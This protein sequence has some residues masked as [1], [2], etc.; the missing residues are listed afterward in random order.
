MKYINIVALYLFSLLALSASSV[1]A[2]TYYVSQSG[3]GTA[4]TYSSPCAWSTGVGK[5]IPGDTIYIKG[6]MLKGL[7]LSKSGTSSARITITGDKVSA[8]ASYSDA[9]LVKGA[10]VTISDLEITGGGNFGLRVTGPHAVVSNVLVHD[11]VLNNRNTNGDCKEPTGGWGRGLTFAYTAD[12]AEVSNSQVY[13]N[14]GEGIAFTQNEHSYLHD[15]LAYDNFS[16]NLYIGNA[17]YVTVEGFT[18]YY[19]GN[20]YFYRG[21]Q[22]GRC[23]GLAIETT[24]YSLVGNLMHDTLIQNNN[25][26]NCKG[27]NFYQEVSGQYPSRV[28]VQYNYIYSMVGCSGGNSCVSI[29]GTN[30]VIRNNYNY[31][32]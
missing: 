32:P 3:S 13:R 1:V 30:I 23:I 24:N 21:G 16:R 15:T 2:N 7:S 4:C 20:P 12:Y 26:H 11:S 17:A 8:P 10:Y 31:P 5:L 22:P 25:V 28:T 18:T 19:S 27:I 6:T 9:L 14:C 29:P